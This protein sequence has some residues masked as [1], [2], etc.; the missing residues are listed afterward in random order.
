MG[1][2]KL[3]DHQYM[4]SVISEKIEKLQ[5]WLKEHT[6]SIC[7]L[8]ANWCSV[9]FFKKRKPNVHVFPPPTWW[10]TSMKQ[11]CDAWPTSSACKMRRLGCR[12][13]KTGKRRE[14]NL[15]EKGAGFSARRRRRWQSTS[16]LFL[17]STWE[18]GF[19]MIFLLGSFRKSEFCLNPSSC[20]PNW[21][22][23]RKGT[24]L[25]LFIFGC[26]ILAEHVVREFC[27]PKFLVNGL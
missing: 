15:G 5:L 16:F 25:F 22:S 6:K 7:L 14:Q 1:R 27:F 4:H 8:T 20:N 26:F 17:Y 19:Q 12:S 9:N 24:S 3:I 23:A 18:S 10:H 21:E 2:M 13:L 11:F